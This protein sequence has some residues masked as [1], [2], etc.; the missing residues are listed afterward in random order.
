MRIL[1]PVEFASRR[2]RHKAPR[3]LSVN[4][5]RRSPTLQSQAGP[6]NAQ[7]P[8]PLSQSGPHAAFNIPPLP[9]EPI[10]DSGSEN[11]PLP[12][13]FFEREPAEQN[14]EPFHP[15]SASEPPTR[16]TSRPDGAP[17]P[18][19]PTILEILS[20]ETP[21]MITL[22]RLLDAVDLEQLREFEHVPSAAYGDIIKYME[23]AALLE[24]Q[25]SRFASG[26]RVDGRVS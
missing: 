24:R 15:P 25:L 12:A 2:P 17:A 18:S 23:A 26:L 3:N 13:L 19:I 9:E 4:Q 20:R 6:S 8:D 10:D 22:T 16:P 5:S 7:R 14:H 1:A 11:E 21:K